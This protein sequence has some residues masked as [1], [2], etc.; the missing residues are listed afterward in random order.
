MT[1]APSCCLRGSYFALTRRRRRGGVI[2]LLIFLLQLGQTVAASAAA[3]EDG[4]VVFEGLVDDD[5]QNAAIESQAVDMAASSLS[6]AVATNSHVSTADNTSL[7][8]A[9]GRS[10]GNSD[11][12]IA[13]RAKDDRNLV[14]RKYAQ[15]KERARK[16]AN[17]KW[18]S[19]NKKRIR[20]RMRRRHRR[21]HEQTLSDR[22]EEI[23][24]KKMTTTTTTRNKV[25]PNVALPERIQDRADD[26]SSSEDKEFATRA[27]SRTRDSDDIEE[28]IQSDSVERDAPREKHDTAVQPDLVSVQQQQSDSKG[29]RFKDTEEEEDDDDDDDGAQM[30]SSISVSDNFIISWRCA[31]PG[32][33]VPTTDIPDSVSMI[34]QPSF[35]TPAPQQTRGPE[36]NSWLKGWSLANGGFGKRGRKKGGVRRA[37]EESKGG[38]VPQLVSSSTA[39]DE[40]RLYILP[41]EHRFCRDMIFRC[42]QICAANPDIECRETFTCRYATPGLTAASPFQA[43]KKRPPGQNRLQPLPIS[44]SRRGKGKGGKG[45]SSDDFSTNKKHREGRPR[46]LEEDSFDTGLDLVIKDGDSYDDL[47]RSLLGNSKGTAKIPAPAPV[48][49]QLTSVTVQPDCTSTNNQLLPTDYFIC[50]HIESPPDAD[51]PKSLPQNSKDY[52]AL[53]ENLPNRCKDLMDPDKTAPP[54]PK[55]PVANDNELT[56]DENSPVTANILGEFIYLFEVMEA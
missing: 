51:C 15:T 29:Y 16:D 4:T 17:K 3:E 48:G 8:S 19:L 24:E 47:P 37:A 34:Q 54:P 25:S 30:V 1:A 39:I 33:N 46:S 52:K 2:L 14:Q 45:G 32:E 20:F 5:A 26:A 44:N 38:G 49:P 21:K 42:P 22:A 10:E 50:S 11:G 43:E 7:F 56:T 6:S 31:Y 35:A 28:A 40:K 18:K 23:R 41:P 55:A 36:R 13:S 9:A 27:S 53:L 12:G